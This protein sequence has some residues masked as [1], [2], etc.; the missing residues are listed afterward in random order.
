M[1]WLFKF[2]ASA[3]FKFPASA[4]FKV[5]EKT[6]LKRGKRAA[7][8]HSNPITPSDKSAIFSLIIIL[9]YFSNIL[10]FSSQNIFK[11]FGTDKERA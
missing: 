5:L 2:P 11:L 1:F 9:I 4:L 8:S 7:I 6:R 10:H 3:F